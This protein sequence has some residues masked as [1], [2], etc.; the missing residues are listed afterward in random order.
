MKEKIIKIAN[1]IYF[2]VYLFLGE[3]F[4]RTFIRG[5]KSYYTGFWGIKLCY[6]MVFLYSYGVMGVCWWLVGED[7][8]RFAK[9]SSDYKFVY[10]ASS[11]FL[12]IFITRLTHFNDDKGL[13]Y[14]E[15]FVREPRSVKIKWKIISAFVFILGIILF[16]VGSLLFLIMRDGNLG[17]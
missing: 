2:G 3:A 6:I 4:Y 8:F 5:E 10:V 7:F 17:E 9:Y 13:A 14:F 12:C 15:Q 1:R 11:V 16:A